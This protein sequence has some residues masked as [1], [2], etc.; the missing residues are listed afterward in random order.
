[1]TPPL[2]SDTAIAAVLAALPGFRR[3]GVWLRAGYRFP[4]FVDA[5]AFTTAIAAA[6]ERAD[7]HPEWTVRYRAVDVALTTHEAGGITERDLGLAVAIGAAA[8][9]GGGR[10]R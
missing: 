10:P 1:M 7:H 4:T 6:A 5:V 3:D 9:T 2:A 8:A